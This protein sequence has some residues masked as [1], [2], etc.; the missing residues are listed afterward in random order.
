MAA[1][2]SP[3]GAAGVGL[4]L[5]ILYTAPPLAAVV[6]A[7]LGAWALA[8]AATAGYLLGVLGRMF[9]G[10]ATGA[11][12]WPDALAHPVSIALLGWL[13][14]RSYRLHRRRRLTWKGRPV[15]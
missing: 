3:L 12:V 5:V 7:A 10:R 13:V 11:R 15:P 1:Y 2:G 8:A 9:S 14:V 6:A 4:I